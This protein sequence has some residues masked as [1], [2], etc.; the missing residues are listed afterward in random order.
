MGQ[1]KLWTKDFLIVSAENFFI[2]LTY[3]LLMVTITVAA[4]HGFSYFDL[5][6]LY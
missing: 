2:Y 6:H 1:T 5:L 4:S 3:Y